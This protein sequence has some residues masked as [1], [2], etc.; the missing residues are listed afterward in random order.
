MCGKEHESA[1][2]TL[3][4]RNEERRRLNTDIFHLLRRYQNIELALF[5]TLHQ[6]ER[7]QGEN[8]PSLILHNEGLLDQIKRALAT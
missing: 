3:A 5:Y 8:N 1:E 4:C 6:I 7:A 2:E